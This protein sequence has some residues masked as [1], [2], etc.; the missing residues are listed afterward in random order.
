MLQSSTG[1][2][3]ENNQLDGCTI[4]DYSTQIFTEKIC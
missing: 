4:S 1:T 3:E 2:T